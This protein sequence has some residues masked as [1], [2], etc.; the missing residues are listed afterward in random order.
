LNVKKDQEVFQK[1]PS[2]FPKLSHQCGVLLCD[3]TKILEVAHAEDAI[4]MFRATGPYA[5]P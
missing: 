4:L 5:R 1:Q 3:V 2:S